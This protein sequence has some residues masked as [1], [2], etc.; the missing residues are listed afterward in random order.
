MLR[1]F[2]KKMDAQLI[3][4][5]LAAALGKQFYAQQIARLDSAITEFQQSAQLF[6]Q[7]IQCINN[8]EKGISLKNVEILNSRLQALEGAF[9]IDFPIGDEITRCGHFRHVV[10]HLSKTKTIFQ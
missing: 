3:H 2:L 4:I 7:I 6:Q 5:G 8:G 9:I 10:F 1:E